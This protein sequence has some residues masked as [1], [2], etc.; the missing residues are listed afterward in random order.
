MNTISVEALAAHL[1]ALDP[2]KELIIDVRTPEEYASGHIPGAVNRIVDTIEE[3][4]SELAQY[5]TVYVHCKSGGRSAQ[6]CGRLEL[7]GL[8]NTVN[9]EGGALAWAAAGFD[10][11]K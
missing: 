9:V 2:Q 7:I 5:E 1:P 8:H 6:A 11:E 3:A 4:Q 10:L